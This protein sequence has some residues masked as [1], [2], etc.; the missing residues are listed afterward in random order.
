[1]LGSVGASALL[2]GLVVGTALGGVHALGHGFGLTLAA[3]LLGGLVEQTAGAHHLAQY[4]IQGFV[5]GVFEVGGFGVSVEGGVLSGVVLVDEVLHAH[6]LLLLRFGVAFS[7]EYLFVIGHSLPQ[8]YQGAAH[9]LSI[10]VVDSLAQGFEATLAGG[11]GQVGF[12][13][14]A[15]PDVEAVEQ[16]QYALLLPPRAHQ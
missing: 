4:L 13:N 6:Q 7:G 11:H 5:V 1:M 14:E 8:H 3:L 15:Q 12:G 2:D 9:V 16:G 10:A